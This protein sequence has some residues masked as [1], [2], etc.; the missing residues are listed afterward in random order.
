MHLD[1]IDILRA[2]AIILVFLYHAQIILFPTYRIDSF[3]PQGI[4]EFASTRDALLNLSPIAFG[5]S[6]VQLFL[7]ISGFLIHLGYLR[8]LDKGRVFSV[9]EFFSKRFWRIY[10]PYL[11]AL[12]FFCFAI[13]GGR[14]LMR[15]D[16][17]ADLASHLLLV[18]N[19]SDTTFFTINPAFWSIAVEAQLYVI[20]PI[21]LLLRKKL[22]IARVLLGTVILAILLELIKPFTSPY[23]G[24]N[25]YGTS[26]FAFWY[27]WCAGAFLAE[28]FHTGKTIFGH[29]KTALLISMTSFMLMTFSICTKATA[30]F[31]V[32][33]AVLAWISFFE[34][35]LYLPLNE[36]HTRS[37]PFRAGVVIGLCSYSIYLFHQPYL[38]TIMLFFGDYGFFPAAVMIKLAVSFAIIV[39]LSY[40]LYVFVELPSIAI[41]AK[42]RAARKGREIS[43]A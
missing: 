8:G 28:R 23:I 20:F 11:L 32:P 37:I 21:L 42:R 5:W 3:D 15:P 7:I 35:F 16:R 17:I 40:S 33:L 4:L 36:R 41:G 1:R 27:I 39:L 18:H 9:R 6:G 19:L 38:R 10:P 31:T 43:E 29:R 25:A 24:D 14:Y 22:G 13:Q 34:W 12:L 2:F 30:P 26:V